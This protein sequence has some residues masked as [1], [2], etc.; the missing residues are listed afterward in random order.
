MART[1]KGESLKED[2]HWFGTR[3]EESTGCFDFRGISRRERGRAEA[4]SAVRSS[5]MNGDGSEMAENRTFSVLRPRGLALEL[6]NRSKLQN[7]SL[8]S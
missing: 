5:E 7:S 6:A 3:G 8:P 1:S 4:F 2:L